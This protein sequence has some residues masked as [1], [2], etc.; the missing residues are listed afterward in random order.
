MLPISRRNT[1]LLGG[2]GAAGIIAGGAGVW[3]TLTSRFEPVAG[4]AFS[5]PQELRSSNGRLRV[6]LEAA[7]GTVLLAGRSATGLAY[8]GGVPGPTLRLRG[9]DTLDIELVNSMAVAT[10]L[11]LHG[12]HVSPEG[13]SDNIFLKVQPGTSFS[14]EYRLPDNHPPGLFWYHP[15]HHGT[16]AD[17]IF[18]GLFGALI[19]EDPEPLQVSRERVMV[20]SDTTLDGAGT[21][22]AASPMERML[23][24][25]GDL[26]LVN[27]QSNPTL[28][29]R[30]GERE[31]WRI[32]NTCVARYLKLRL[33]GQQLQLLG[34]DSGRLRTPERI[35]ELLL[36]PGNRA[37]LLVTATAG[38]ATLTANYYDRGSMTGVMGLAGPGAAEDGGSSRDGITLASLA[39]AGEPAAPA[40]VVPPAEQP[41]DLRDAVV[42]ARRQFTFETGG[43]GPGRGPGMGMMS[44]TING[45]NFNGNRTDT[46]VALQTIEEWTIVNSSFMDHPFHLHVWPMQIVQ[47][48]GSAPDSAPW[49]DVVN[50]PA[51]GQ[52]TVRIAFDDF[53]GRSVYHC[54]IL[55]HEDQGMMGVIEVR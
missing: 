4:S 47:A 15:H 13:N 20:I 1:L 3:W 7:P 5:G 12:L 40:P 25:E 51:R 26:V 54:H 55:D 11:H 32:V 16:V 9:G 14:Y 27:G 21:V 33:D 10:N 52:V 8:N 28:S 41:A 48:A 53:P 38:D 44:F 2:L 29:A 24:R 22:A 18:A 46:A 43:M 39:V 37:D 35:Q 23:G 19:V 31:R 34:M 6:R 36:A 49:R 42:A 17:Q 45:R 50:V 30:P